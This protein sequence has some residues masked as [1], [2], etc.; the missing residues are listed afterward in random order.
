[1]GAHML[2]V[3]PREIV[4]TVTRQT[5]KF[6]ASFDEAGDPDQ[7]FLSFEAGHIAD[8]SAVDA[9]NKLGER[10]GKLNKHVQLQQLKPAS[11]RVVRKSA[12]LLVKEIA[13]QVEEEE[14][15]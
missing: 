2:T 7:V 4:D 15:L 13:M 10:Y 9:L 12:G 8:F 14:A 1:M 11:E 3:T 5:T 6:Y